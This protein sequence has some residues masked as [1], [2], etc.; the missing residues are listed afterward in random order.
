VTIEKA[1]FRFSKNT[2]W[3]KSHGNPALAG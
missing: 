3:R 1:G 2:N